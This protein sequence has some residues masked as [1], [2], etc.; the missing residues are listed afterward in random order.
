MSKTN[1]IRGGISGKVPAFVAYSWGNVHEISSDVANFL[2]RSADYFSIIIKDLRCDEN[3]RE[4]LK[5]EFPNLSED[6]YRA[7]LNANVRGV[8]VEV[9]GYDKAKS[10]FVSKLI[11][12][13]N[14]LR[15][16]ERSD[17]KLIEKL[18]K[19][20]RKHG[21]KEIVLEDLFKCD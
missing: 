7:I 4:M 13:R 15:V 3:D 16:I 14:K 2:G 1:D 17:K 19:V 18:N 6:A 9:F 11:D 20:L 21:E 5:E 10:E 8:E 12:L